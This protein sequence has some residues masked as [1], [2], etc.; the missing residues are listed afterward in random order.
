[1][2]NLN[3]ISEALQRGRADKISELVRKALNENTTPK[4]IL[5]EGLIQAMS[6]I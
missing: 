4:N 6:I 5:E 3:D 1:M 2:L